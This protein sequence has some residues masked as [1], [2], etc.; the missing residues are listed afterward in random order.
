MQTMLILVMKQAELTN[1]NCTEYTT[2]SN[3]TSL[4]KRNDIENG[5]AAGC[6]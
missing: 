5:S 3:S 2:G 6:W 1:N 4:V